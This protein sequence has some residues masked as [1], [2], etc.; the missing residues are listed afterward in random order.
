MKMSRYP[1]HSGPATFLYTGRRDIASQSMDR[2]TRKYIIPTSNTYS[3]LTLFYF[4]Y[5][6]RLGTVYLL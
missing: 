2:Y 3:A 5:I 1:C 6:F 4:I